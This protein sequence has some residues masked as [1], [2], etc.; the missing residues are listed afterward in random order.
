MKRNK[1]SVVEKLLTVLLVILVMAYISY[2]AYRSVFNAVETELATSHSVYESFDTQGIVFR[3]ETIIPPA[4]GGH[5]YYMIENG[6]RVAKDSAIAA[7]YSDPQHGRIKQ[8]IEELDQQIADLRS[9]EADGS[10]GRITLD[11]LN[12][13]LDNALF[14]MIASVDNGVFDDMEQRKSSL[15]SLLSKRRLVTGDTVDF[16][17]KIAELENE[18][19]ALQASYKQAKSVIDAPIAGYFADKTDGYENMVSIDELDGMTV[20]ALQEQ[21]TLQPS[22]VAETAGKIVGGYEWYMGCIV[23]DSYYNALGEGNTLTLR[24]AFVTDEEIPVVVHS[25]KKDNAGNMAVIF[26]C[27]YMSKELSTI[28]LE[29]V[30]IQLVSHTGLKVSKRAIV[31]DENQ[32]TG[33]YVRTGNIATFRKIKQIYSEPADYVICEEVKESGYLKVYDDVIVGGRGLYDGKIID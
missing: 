10:S 12:E 7:I 33:V 29:E 31:L 25:C 11:V 16:S 5:L 2:Q 21:L 15:L 23:P 26:R 32:Q 6:T 3:A 17:K 4:S 20:E 9:I 8:Q 28:R 24:M 27:D 19:K 13:Q 22:V 18:K 1:R 30:Q 14:T